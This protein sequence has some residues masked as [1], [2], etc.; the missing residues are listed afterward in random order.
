MKQAPVAVLGAGSWG[1]ALAMVLSRRGREVRL[2]ERT[3]LLAREMQQKR[4]N[5]H[6]LPGITFP[7]SLSVTADYDKALDGT[8]ATIL[9]VPC[10]AADSVLGNISGSSTPVIAACKGLDPDSL[11]RVD[12]LLIRHVGIDRAALLSGPSFARDSA[13]GLPT[14]IT[15]A[16]ADLVFARQCAGLFD[17]HAFRIYT[18]TDLAGVALGG[19]LK[20]VIAIAAGISSGLN[21]GHSAIAALI[22][23]GIAEISRLAVACG[24]R[25]ETMSGLSGLGD[26]VLTCTGELSRNRKMG[27]ALAQGMRVDEARSHVGQ[28][29][30]GEKT[31]I[32]ACKLAEKHGIEMPISEIVR[33]VLEEKIRPDQAVSRLL[34]RP[35]KSE[36]T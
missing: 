7:E 21:L 24:G 23:R 31:T 28:V 33:S 8:V 35:E 29:V 6:F 13:E 25:P 27:I 15:M 9:A 17:D 16:A 4:Q 11:E 10:S 32:A 18:S 19:A 20:N 30:E 2:F 14:A 12:E 1:T 22:T 36:Y 34:N 5:S 3:D 26:L